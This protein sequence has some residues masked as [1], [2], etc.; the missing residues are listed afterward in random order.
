MLFTS[1]NQFPLDFVDIVVPRCWILLQHSYNK[2]VQI[3][4][5]ASYRS[6]SFI[7]CA[8]GKLRCKQLIQYEPQ[9]V[10]VCSFIYL[11]SARPLL[12]RGVLKV[13]QTCTVFGL[14]GSIE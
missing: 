4:V 12:R 5:V 8:V 6:D 3:W 1:R 14:Y 2:R 11:L 10:Y 13:R 9:C 7:V